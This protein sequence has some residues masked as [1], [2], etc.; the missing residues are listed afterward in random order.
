MERP[1]KTNEARHI[2][3]FVNGL[4]KEPSFHAMVR[5]QIFHVYEVVKFSFVMEGFL[6]HWKRVEMDPKM[7]S[8]AVLCCCDG[9]KT[10]VSA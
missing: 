2:L 4:A 10:T 3:N 6:A 8:S 9:A 1:K 5:R 7:Y